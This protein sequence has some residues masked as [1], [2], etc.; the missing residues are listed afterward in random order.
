MEPRAEERMDWEALPGR[1][2]VPKQRA[3]PTGKK[4]NGTQRDFRMALAL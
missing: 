1:L 3:L 2:G 4:T